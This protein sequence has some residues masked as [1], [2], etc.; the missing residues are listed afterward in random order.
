MSVTVCALAANA[1]TLTPE[2]AM[3]SND[4]GKAEYYDFSLGVYGNPTIDQL[5]IEN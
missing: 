2:Q 3:A 1:T 5:P 4:S